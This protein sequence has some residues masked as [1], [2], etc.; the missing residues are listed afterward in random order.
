MNIKEKVVVITGSTKG[1]GRALAEAFIKAGARVVVS[2]RDEAETQSVAA[3][4][5]AFGIAADVT[6]EADVTRLAEKTVERFG[7]LDIWINNAGVWLPH[8]PVEN[9]DMANVHTVFE[10]NVFGAM[11]GT[12]SALA[13]MR[14]QGSGA[15]INIVSTSGLTAKAFDSGYCAS[16]FAVTGFT[17]AVQKEI[18]G[19]AIKLI[20]VYPSRMQ[21]DLFDAQKP[22][23]IATYMQPGLVAQK[24]IENLLSDQPQADLIIENLTK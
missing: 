20:A 24:I 7:Q 23:D 15:I 16:K 12:R 3:A 4:V 14:K 6:S 18:E 11:Y 9:L 2:S 17:K 8:G 22:D 1:L 10:V 19:S 21:T 13:C 5:G